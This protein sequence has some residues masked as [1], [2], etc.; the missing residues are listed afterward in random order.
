MTR[1]GRGASDDRPSGQLPANAVLAPAVLRGIRRRCGIAVPGSPRDPVVLVSHMA[2]TTG[3]A[4]AGIAT[5]R[6][7]DAPPDGLTL[8]DVRPLARQYELAILHTSTPS[9]AHDVRV[10]EALKTE[11]PSLRIGLVGAHVAVDPKAALEASEAIEF[12]AASEFDF[13]IQEI[14]QGR[15]LASVAGLSYRENRRIRHTLERPVLENMD[16]L[17][18]AVDVYRRDP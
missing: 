13:T 10:S 18:F 1:T 9:F 7:A 11:N 3:S 14:A 4:R 5:R 2:R 8:Y 6:R 12:V 15:P 16:A 17:P